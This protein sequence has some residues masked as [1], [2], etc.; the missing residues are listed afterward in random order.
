MVTADSHATRLT[1]TSS[2]AVCADHLPGLRHLSTACLLWA[3]TWLA[4]AG[5]AHQGVSIVTIQAALTGGPHGE[6]CTLTYTWKQINDLGIRA[7]VFE[8]RTADSAR[9]YFPGDTAAAFRKQQLK[10]YKNDMCCLAY[11]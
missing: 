11:E 10:F 3:G 4:V 1:P 9:P 8:E 5:T 2:W 6:V 7:V